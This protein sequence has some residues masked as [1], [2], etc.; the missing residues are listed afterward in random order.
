MKLALIPLLALVL[1][2][3]GLQDKPVEIHKNELPKTPVAAFCGPNGATEMEPPNVGYRYKGK[4]YY[5]CDKPAID[6]FLK[7]PEGFLPL[8]IPRPAPEFAIKNL[9]GEK[10]S[11]DNYKGKVVLLDFWAT[12]CKPCVTS[13]P[14][15]QKLHAKYADK[16]LI[17]LGV[18]IDEKGA[19]VV[20]PFIEKRKF[21]YPIAL[22][23]SDKPAWKSYRVKGVPAL[24]LIDKEGDIIRQWTGKPDKKEV[25]EAVQSALK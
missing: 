10:V 16:G 18:S 14:E 20:K 6:A 25:E 9:S 5:F 2:F 7:D 24:F 3:G 17:V 23:S 22:D 15:L 8:P 13:M 1:G 4:A 19:K 11:L 12:W 21:S